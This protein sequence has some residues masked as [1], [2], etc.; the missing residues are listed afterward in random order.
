MTPE[1]ARS[2]VDAIKAIGR[3]D[4]EAAHSMEDDLYHRFVRSV[5]SMLRDVDVTW[6]DVA[7]IIQLAQIVME[8]EDI[9]FPRWRA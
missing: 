6:F 7:E 9:Y 5:D 2:V 4:P 3:S 8:T 1:E